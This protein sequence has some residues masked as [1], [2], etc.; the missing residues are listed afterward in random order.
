MTVVIIGTT[1]GI[2]AHPRARHL[3][4]ACT[5]TWRVIETIDNTNLR[6]MLFKGLWRHLKRAFS[7]NVSSCQ[8]QKNNLD[9]HAN[10]NECA[11]TGD[12]IVEDNTNNLIDDNESPSLAKRLRI[13]AETD[14][15]EAERSSNIAQLLA[16]RQLLTCNVCFD[17]AKQANQ[18]AN[19]HL[20]CLSCSSRLEQVS[21]STDEA[22]A[23]CACPVCRVSLCNSG[24]G[25]NPGCG[26][27]RCLLAEKLAAELPVRCRYCETYFPRK[28]IELHQRILCGLR[29]VKCKFA[30]LGC[31]WRGFAQDLAE[32]SAECTVLG[33]K[34]GDVIGEVYQQMH[35]ITS[36]ASIR[37]QPWRGL[38]QILEDRQKI[39]FGRRF[40]AG[41]RLTLLPISLEKTPNEGNDTRFKSPLVCMPMIGKH[42]LWVQVRI[43]KFKGLGCL[44][45]LFS[46]AP[47]LNI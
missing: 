35:D 34:T 26:M 47:I 3:V 11:A 14:K 16:L 4:S 36:T 46:T 42:S 8:L 24:D 30:W 20:I 22:K 10:L 27:Q 5:V 17:V 41:L 25:S 7:V 2:Q 38:L 13:E 1:K 44:L 19:G 31:E 6:R 15:P 40:N 23:P 9:A 43:T 28:I 45:N 33:Q 39:R 21:F 29:L 12:V 32:H 18:C 37:L